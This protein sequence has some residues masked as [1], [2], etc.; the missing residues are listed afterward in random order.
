MCIPARLKH[1]DVRPRWPRPAAGGRDR[2]EHEFAPRGRVRQRCAGLPAQRC[3]S[4]A[5]CRGSAKAT[6]CTR[7]PTRPAGTSTRRPHGCACGAQN[8]Y[9]ALFP[10]EPGELAEPARSFADYLRERERA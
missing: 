3:A 6:A 2:G 10:L 7:R 4:A 8:Y 9:W 5:S 1:P